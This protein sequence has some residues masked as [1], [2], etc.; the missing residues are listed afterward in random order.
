MKVKYV[1]R[2]HDTLDELLVP[3]VHSKGSCL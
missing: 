1:L 3:N 2:E